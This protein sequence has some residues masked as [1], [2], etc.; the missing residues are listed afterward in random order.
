VSQ[1]S[2]THRVEPYLAQHDHRAGEQLSSTVRAAIGQ[3]VAVL[4]LPTQNAYESAYV[5]QEI[6][7]ALERQRLVIPLLDPSLRSADLGMLQGIHWISFDLYRPTP[8]CMADLSAT[9]HRLSQVASPR[10]AQA[11]PRPGIDFEMNF[12][13]EIHLDRNDLLLAGGV[14]LLVVGLFLLL[15][16]ADGAA[17]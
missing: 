15:N 4:V 2:L 3:S 5:H 8:Q 16:E 13:A 10:L 6:G 11:P 7:V 17:S 14:A 1:L 9:L 12:H